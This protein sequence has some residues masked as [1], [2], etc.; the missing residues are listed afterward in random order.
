MS[1]I[2]FMSRIYS[3]LYK[4]FQPISGALTIIY[5]IWF[6]NIIYDLIMRTRARLQYRK[7]RVTY[8]LVR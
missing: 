2:E 3:E 7:S 4:G 8:W 5:G 1:N 6:A